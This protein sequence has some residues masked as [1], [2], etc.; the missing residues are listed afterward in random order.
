MLRRLWGWPTRRSRQDSLG[1]WVMGTQLSISRWRSSW[2]QP[3][4]DNSKPTFVGAERSLISPSSYICKQ[5]LRTDPSHPLWKGGFGAEFPMHYFALHDEQ[6]AP[7]PAT[8]VPS[9]LPPPGPAA[10]C[11]RRAAGARWPGCCTAAPS[12]S[13]AAPGPK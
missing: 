11:W 3:A 2:K 12:R 10:S 5:R 8:S 7:S 4:F 1:G 6:C 13:P 9:S